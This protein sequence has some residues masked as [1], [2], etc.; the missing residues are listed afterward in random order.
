M[1]RA[2]ELRESKASDNGYNDKQD[3]PLTATTYCCHFPMLYI[4]QERDGHLVHRTKVVAILFIP[5]PGLLL[6]PFI[7]SILDTCH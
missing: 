5:N 7:K 3:A 4:K 6:T 2:T 1:T